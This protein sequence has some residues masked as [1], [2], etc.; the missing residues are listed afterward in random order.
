MTSHESLSNYINPNKKNIYSYLLSNFNNYISLTKV[1]FV[2]EIFT[3]ILNG[4]TLVL[5]SDE[6]K[7][8][9]HLIANLINNYDIEGFDS[10]P[11]L[12]NMYFDNNEFIKSLSKLKTIFLGGEPFP[13]ELYNKLIKLSPAKIVDCYGLTETTINSNAK[14]LNGSMNNSIGKPLFNVIERVMDVDGHSLPAGI[15]GELWIGG[16]G[17]AKGYIN[18]PKIN[19]K[20]FTKINNVPFYKTGDLARL[21]DNGDYSYHGRLDT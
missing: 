16:L 2:S 19:N 1:S 10:T 3:S 12:V 8:N 13:Y 7:N 21:E 11:L 15:I 20:L 14:I 18:N 5:A 4:V 6:S 17:V 9:P